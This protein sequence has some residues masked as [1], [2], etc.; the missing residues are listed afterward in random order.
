MA[1]PDRSLRPAPAERVLVAFSGGPDSTA[2]ALLAVSWGCDVVL[3]HVDHA[4]RASSSEDA[5][6]CRDVA[7]SLGLPIEVVRLDEAPAGE[8]AARTARYEALE[9]MADRVGASVIATGHTLDDDAETVLLRL[10][11]G[12]YPLGIPPRRG[13]VV[14]PL[15]SMR[16]WETARMCAIR[17]V[18][19]LC[20]PTNLDERFAR[21]RIRHRVLPLV[22]DDGVLELA[23]L[24]EAT[25]EAKA[26]RDAALD[27]LAAALVRR[28]APGTVLCLDRP[29][30]AALPEGPRQGVVRRVLQ[31]VGID[32][33]SRLVRDLSVKV[34]PVP[35]ARLDL[36]DGLT[37][38]AEPQELLAGRPLPPPPEAP[39]VAPGTTRL[40]DW[41]IE[42]RTEVVAPPASPRTG[43]W[44]A[45]LDGRT[46]AAPLAVRSRRP[47]DRYRP[48]GAPGERKLQDILVDG[49]VPRAI[50]DR[51]P[52]LTAGGRLVWVAG[53]RIAHDFRITASSASALRVRILPLAPDLPLPAA[54]APEGS[55]PAGNLSTDRGAP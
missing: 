10:G 32:P 42:V 26:R 34:V 46:A 37:A 22:G 3:G 45:L 31:S 17:G 15:L 48:L 52:L 23:R 21:N 1:G 39:I 49:K 44:E 19:V 7:A 35:G 8:A 20:D 29:S 5:R 14:R 2:L 12:G 51:V 27:R 25:R 13:R 28:P 43:P 11:R 47:G 38:W 6:H 18:P 9:R 55:C 36:P 40:P 50:R 16:R 53:H 33:S 24:A 54:L 41:G 4:M 30:L